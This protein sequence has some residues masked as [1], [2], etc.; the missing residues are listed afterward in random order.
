M[1]NDA[2]LIR[3]PAAP[4]RHAHRRRRWPRNS[5]PRWRSAVPT[6]T[7]D[8]IATRELLTALDETWER[9]WQPADVVHAAR[10]EA[11]AG[12]VPLAVALI[13]EHARRSDAGVRAPDAW[14]DQL[15]RTG[16]L[17]PGDPAVVGHLAPG[18]AAVAGRGVAH[19]AAARRVAAHGRAARD[20]GAAAVAVGSAP[21]ACGRG[22]RPGDDRVL[23]RHPRPA[24]QGGVDRVPGGGGVADRQGAGADDPA[25]GRRGD[26]RAG[27]PPAGRGG[28]QARARPATRTSARRC[29]C[30]QRSRRPTTSGWSGTSRLGIANLVG[31]A[32]RRRRGGAAV[33]VAAAAGGAGADRRGAAVGTT[34]GVPDVPQGVPARLRAPDRGAAPG[35]Q[36]PRHRRGGGRARRRPAPGVAS[37]QEAVDSGSPSCSRTCGPPGAERRSTPAAGTPDRRRR[38]GPTSGTAGRPCADRGTLPRK[39]ATPR[40]TT[41]STPAAPPCSAH[42][43]RAG[44]FRGSVAPQDTTDVKAAARLPAGLP[45]RTGRFPRKRRANR[46]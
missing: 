37:R 33:H 5:R 12:S 30:W 19:R 11:T 2:W 43:G 18:G 13:G 14:V 23:R 35:G 17:S 31:V 41:T 34:V 46:M 42:P 44:R 26:A 8:G 3:P 24:G 10:K 21:L 4:L 45:D 29:S 15:S 16:R 20:S 22:A 32:G 39:R 9:G 27:P 1:S 25:R 28:H 6:S 40:T 7:T 38:N 36:A